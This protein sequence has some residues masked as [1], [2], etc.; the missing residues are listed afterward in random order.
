MKRKEAMKNLFLFCAICAICGCCSAQDIRVA[1]SASASAFALPVPHAT[2]EF[3][4]VRCADGQPAGLRRPGP[5]PSACYVVWTARAENLV[6]T[7]G[8]NDLLTKYFKGSSYNATWYVGLIDLTTF[9]AVAAT[10]TAAKIN[11]TANPPTTNGWQEITAYSEGA[12]PALVLGTASSG[13][14][15]NTASKAAFS[16]NA[17]KTI[18]GGFLCSSATWG[19]TATILYSAAAFSGDKAVESGDTLNV[20]ITL[21]EA[22]V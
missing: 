9:T 17:T 20:T 3:E 10:D 1:A 11:T 5:P 7:E 19:G 18:H 15:S 21:T 4:L 6:T 22:T 2:Y 16:I 12:R 8:L 13:S 14:I